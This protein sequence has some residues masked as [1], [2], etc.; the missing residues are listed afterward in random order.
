MKFRYSLQVMTVALGLNAACI[1]AAYA[2]FAIIAFHFQKTASVGS[3][4]IPVYYAAAMATGA[5]GSL[6]LGK[7]FD[8]IGLRVVLGVFFLSMFFAPLVFLGR[9]LIALAGMALWGLGMAAQG[10]LLNSLI[11]GVIHPDKRSTAF[12]VFDTGFGVAWF[13]GS[14]L[15]GVLYQ[16][17]IGAVIV[18]SVVLQFLALPIF[19][20]ARKS[21]R[22]S[23][24]QET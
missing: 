1:G 22:S 23:S 4:L 2:D 14:W 11:S 10:S 13:L 9:G 5:I 21:E 24:R 6:I 8:E 20:F 18:F 16:R 3:N 7:L 17:S 19:V 15:M 12:G